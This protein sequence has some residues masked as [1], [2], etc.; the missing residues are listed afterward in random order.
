MT[1]TVR[2]YLPPRYCSPNAR[3]SWYLVARDRA[4]YRKEAFAMFREFHKGQTVLYPEG[5]TVSYEFH[6]MRCRRGFHDGRVG[7]K[8]K[9]NAISCMKAVQDALADACIV[10]NDALVTIGEVVILRTIESTFRG[11]IMTIEQG[12]RRH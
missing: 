11:V 4:D 8:D 9:D 1:H 6:I 7:A 10:S 12:R 5:V 3:G 2:L